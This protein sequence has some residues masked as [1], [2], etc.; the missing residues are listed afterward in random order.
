MILQELKVFR[1]ADAML[2]I[3]ACTP[4]SAHG[5]SMLVGA[6]EILYSLQ[7]VLHSVGG[8]DSGFLHKIQNRMSQLELTTGSWPYL[9]ISDTGDVIE[10]IENDQVL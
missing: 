9:A 5:S 8:R 4:F 1:L 7:H 2:D 10:E 6:G 3:V